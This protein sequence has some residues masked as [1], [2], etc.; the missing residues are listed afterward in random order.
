MLQRALLIGPHDWR[1][2]GGAVVTVVAVVLGQVGILE[3]GLL[4]LCAAP[5]EEDADLVVPAWRGEDVLEFL[6]A[7]VAFC[8]TVEDFFDLI[9]GFPAFV[10]VFGEDGG[11]EEGHG[12]ESQTVEVEGGGEAGLHGCLVEFIG[13]LLRA[14]NDF[15]WAVDEDVALDEE[16]D[17]PVE[18]VLEALEETV[19]RGLFGDVEAA[20]VLDF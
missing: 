10:G 5:F 16:P 14:V 2:G 11:L 7:G 1:R 15:V 12:G 4:G 13:E 17:C 18:L 6:D 9:E 19:G 3:L 8:A 20:E